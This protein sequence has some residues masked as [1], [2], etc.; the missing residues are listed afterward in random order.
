MLSVLS[1]ENEPHRARYTGHILPKI[2]INDYNVMIYGQNFFD[3]Q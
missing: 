2:D 3:H 1:I